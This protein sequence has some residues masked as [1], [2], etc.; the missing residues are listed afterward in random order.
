[1]IPWPLITATKSSLLL[2]SLEFSKERVEIKA[3][4]KKK[5]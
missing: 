1:V 4:E 3:L 5:G 2:E